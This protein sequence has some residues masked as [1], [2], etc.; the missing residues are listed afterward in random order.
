[1]PTIASLQASDPPLGPDG[2]H[3]E[4]HRWWRSLIL[5]LLLLLSI[6]LYRVL[7]TVVPWSDDLLRD[8]M[9]TRF[10]YGWML[11]FVPYF[12]ACAFV[13]GTR[14]TSGYWFWVELAI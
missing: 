11:C 3:P 6:T 4:K 7:I 5:L 9:V 14:A 12:V 2:S 13:L 8:D 10:L 1:M